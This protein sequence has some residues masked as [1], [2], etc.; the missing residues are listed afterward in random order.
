MK[1]QE[2]YVNESVAGDMYFI[3]DNGV[4]RPI[5]TDMGI[6]DAVITCCRI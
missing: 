1:K 3:K 4:G 6:S 2:K 5:Y